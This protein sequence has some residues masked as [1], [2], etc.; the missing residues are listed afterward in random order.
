M[1]PKTAH[2]NNNQDLT[3]LTSSCLT[4][5]SFGFSP[6]TLRYTIK[7]FT[8]TLIHTHTHEECTKTTTFPRTANVNGHKGT[9][10][11]VLHRK[12]MGKMANMISDFRTQFTYS[13]LIIK[14]PEQADSSE[15]YWICIQ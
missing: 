5:C 9:T 12:C 4:A 11:A 14:Q 6:L 10:D 2:D 15:K 3:V 7:Q 13:Y 8:H 1:L